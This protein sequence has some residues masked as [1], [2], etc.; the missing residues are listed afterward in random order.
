MPA[1]LLGARTRFIERTTKRTFLG[2]IH[3]VADNQV[4]VKFEEELIPS[5]VGEVDIIT[6]A[7]FNEFTGHFRV[8]KTEYKTTIFEPM[9]PISEMPMAENIRLLREPVEAVCEFEETSHSLVIVAGG[10]SALA[11]ETSDILPMVDELDIRLCTTSTDVVLKAELILQRHQAGTYRCLAKL[12]DLSR[13][14]RMH[15]LRVLND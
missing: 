1:R 2:K 12:N 4:L 11:F 7:G 6:F 9:A 10:S 3:S 13:I 5:P 15:W 14:A 8:V